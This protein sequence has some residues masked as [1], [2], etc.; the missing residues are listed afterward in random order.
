[1]RN[2]KSKTAKTTTLKKVSQK[3]TVR[4]AFKADAATIKLFK[5]KMTSSVKHAQASDKHKKAA[6][7]EQTK[8]FG[9]LE[10][11]LSKKGFNDPE[12]WS[13]DDNTGMLT[14]NK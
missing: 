1:M 4:K 5:E 3:K 11:E 12:N 13:Y 10:L 8:A 2:S 7:E 14:P 6:I 9:M